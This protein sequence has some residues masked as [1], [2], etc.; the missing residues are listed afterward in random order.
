MQCHQTIW[1]ADKGWDSTLPDASSQLVLAF[2][3]PSA[4][5]D[6]KRWNELD[7]IFPNALIMGCSTGGEIHGCDVV[8][9][10]LTATGLKFDRTAV[11][12]ATVELAKGSF[13]AGVELG[14]RLRRDDLNTV[15]VLADGTV[16]NGSELTRG[17]RSVLSEGTVIAGGLAGDGPRFGTT[18]VGLEKAG[19][20]G[21]AAA[22]GFYGRALD[23]RHGSGGGW[24][25][26]GPE[27][28]VTRSKANILYELDGQPALDLYRRYLGD[29]AEGLP[30]SA[31]LFPLQ[32]Y[33]ANKRQEAIVRTVVGI[34]EADRSMIFAGDIPSGFSA[35]LMR[36]NFDRL[37][38]GAASA[39]EQAH[40][41][42]QGKRVAVLVSCIGRKLLLGQRIG[43]EV[44]AVR[45]VLGSDTA[46]T[47]FYSY[48]EVVPHSA[49]GLAELHNQ[50]MTI[51]VFGER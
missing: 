32:I 34:D 16:A 20:P 26:F 28:K 6:K 17:L 13:E 19:T 14:K 15:F 24:D 40:N 31:L 5:A 37:I 25:V 49:T 18:Y 23:V 50:T 8:D 11:E 7:D 46:L 43:E 4:I 41:P 47:G 22:I 39:A 35:Q 29:H 44:E 51:T 9:E 10:S 33:P 42:A 27:R 38:E 36:G 45:D 48:G 2:G 1:T 30:G 3:S 21:T 12:G